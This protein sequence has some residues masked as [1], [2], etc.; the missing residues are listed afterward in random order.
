MKNFKITEGSQFRAEGY[1]VLNHT[2]YDS[3]DT[4]LGDG[5]TGQVP[6]A[7]QNRTPTA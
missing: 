1:N 7:G 4:D 5:T 6:G 2:N 3:I